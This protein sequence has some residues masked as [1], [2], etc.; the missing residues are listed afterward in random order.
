MPGI[1]AV[2]AVLAKAEALSVQRLTFQLLFFSN[3]QI[4][5]HAR[6]LPTHFRLCYLY[7]NGGEHRR[8]FVL[9][10]LHIPEYVVQHGD[11]GKDVRTFIQHDA[12]GA[13]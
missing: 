4:N 11:G 6:P 1:H 8:F 13:L 2:R 5:N 9:V 7:F 3:P 10:V 12:I